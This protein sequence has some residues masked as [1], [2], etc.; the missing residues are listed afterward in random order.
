MFTVTKQFSFCYGHHLPGYDGRC[1]NQHGHNSVLEV[2][3]SGTLPH[4]PD[5]EGMIMDFS[6][7]KRLVEQEIINELDHKNLN[8]IKHRNGL[9]HPEIKHLHKVREMPTAENILRWIVAV[10]TRWFGGH[11]IRVRLTETPTSWAEWRK[12]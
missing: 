4:L 5:K 10:L 9:E 6:V 7:L 2:E 12:D 8:E 1:K 11:L 3:V